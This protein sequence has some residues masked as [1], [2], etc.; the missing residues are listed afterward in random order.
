M[1]TL[2]LY[3]YII[4]TFS[5]KFLDAYSDS[6]NKCEDTFPFG[7]LS[8]SLLSPCNNQYSDPVARHLKS[9][10]KNSFGA[11]QSSENELKDSNIAMHM[12]VATNIS[13]NPSYSSAK[14]TLSEN[15]DSMKKHSYP[16][17]LLARHSLPF[18]QIRRK[19]KSL[20]SKMK[21]LR[22]SQKK[23]KTSSCCHHCVTNDNGA[24]LNSNLLSMI[25]KGV[26]Q[27]Y[28]E[29][30]ENERKIESKNYSEGKIQSRKRKRSDE[31]SNDSKNP[32]L[33]QCE[34]LGEDTLIEEKDIPLKNA[35]CNTPEEITEEKE[36]NIL[37]S[38][39]AL[40]INKSS[41]VLNINTPNV[42]FNSI[43]Q[44]CEKAIVA[45]TE[46]VSDSAEEAS[47][48]DSEKKSHSNND[49]IYTSNNSLS[50][51]N[52]ESVNES[53][54]ETTHLL[55]DDDNKNYDKHSIDRV[56]DKIHTIVEESKIKGNNQNK[57]KLHNRLLKNIRN[58]KRKTQTSHVN[59]QENIE[60]ESNHGF[61]LNELA[62]RLQVENKNENDNR[63]IQINNV[64]RNLETRANSS[65]NMQEDSATE[66]YSERSKKLRVAHIPKTSLV[67]P[68]V[69]N[70]QD[71]THHTIKNIVNLETSRP[72]YN[73]ILRLGTPTPKNNLL[74][75]D[76]KDYVINK[77]Y[78]EKN[79]VEYTEV[80]SIDR[81]PRSEKYPDTLKNFTLSVMSNK[82]VI[83]ESNK[84]DQVSIEDGTDEYVS[85]NRG[86]MGTT[87]CEEV[88]AQ[89]K[90]IEPGK[91]ITPAIELYSC[92]T[93]TNEDKQ[94]KC[95]DET[96]KNMNMNDKLTSNRLAALA[97]MR[98]KNYN[99]IIAEDS[100]DD[101]NTEESLDKAKSIIENACLNE[102]D[103][104]PVRCVDINEK[105]QTPMY[106]L[107]K[108]IGNKKQIVR[109]RPIKK[110]T[111]ICKLAGI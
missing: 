75:K 110:M 60:S 96:S 44:S 58:L 23:E 72:K 7:V 13:T 62:K 56:D 38:S 18:K 43:D 103:E 97:A 5:F 76:E 52:M 39:H 32:F 25:C 17:D 107:T 82:C 106:R 74:I 21:K 41:P 87:I 9:Q 91:V 88:D 92:D 73:R 49:E 11:T 80:R 63:T 12:P 19:L 6:T 33:S 26:A 64:K 8:T 20:K 104:T 69:N 98:C 46:N 102:R 54:M 68:S 84:S 59:K 40:C 95:C 1:Y 101:N 16:D 109:K 83:S 24:F 71:F 42:F 79:S 14:F 37:Q 57:E 108:Y 27:Y 2:I 10:L 67:P 55:S 111:Y 48:E 70:Q 99:A 86:T 29:K 36:I 34:S 50:E 66:L 78:E 15:I 81:K 3:I 93:I 47:P 85:I 53:V 61:E 90:T 51:S 22:R 4:I 94:D 65:I 35:T 77:N 100:V 105:S 31:Y 89:A 30:R 28:D 45:C